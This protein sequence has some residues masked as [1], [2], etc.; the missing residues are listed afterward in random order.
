ME[1]RIYKKSFY[2][3]ALLLIPALLSGW[4]SYSRYFAGSDADGIGGA[5][6]ADA[7]SETAV[8]YNPAGL[9]QTQSMKSNQNFFFM[10]EVSTS[11]FISD[12]FA[13]DVTAKFDTFPFFAV[14]YNGWDLKAGLSINTLFYSQNKE[15]DFTLHTAHL[16]FAFPIGDSLSIGFGG[17]PAFALERSGVGYSYDYTAGILWKLLPE[18][19]IGACFH[20]PISIAWSS[21]EVGKSLSETFPSITEL[22]LAYNMSGTSVYFFS[23]DYT[24]VDSI[25]YILDG[26]DYSPAIGNNFMARLH[27]HT[28]F[29][30]LEENTGAHISAGF[31]TGSFNYDKGSINQYLLTLGVR[32]YGED[33][34]F[35]ASLIDALILG[36]F[37][38]GNV[39]DEQINLSFDFNF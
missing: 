12:L 39:P 13:W 2:L 20:S 10:Y 33:M 22:G 19:K 23:L 16:T 37:F 3:L 4:R 1:N 21:T 31:M 15:N 8:Y 36:L 27:L 14:A 5:A 7:S 17:G 24:D 9:V 35:R 29:R 34:V 18:L 6:V 30:F 26:S 28:G 25:R 32:A 11:L 38:S